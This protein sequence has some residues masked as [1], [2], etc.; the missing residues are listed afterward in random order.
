MTHCLK[1]VITWKLWCDLKREY[2]TIDWTTVVE[3]DPNYVG[4]D[5]IGA[6]ACAGG[7]CEI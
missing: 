1:H 2:K 4:V 7:K 6:Q 5:T 3:A